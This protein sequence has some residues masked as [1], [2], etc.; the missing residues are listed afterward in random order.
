MVAKVLS[1][2][3][4]ILHLI[5]TIQ[6]VILKYKRVVINRELIAYILIT[7]IANIGM[8]YNFIYFSYNASEIVVFSLVIPS[9]LV[10][11]HFKQVNIYLT[12]FLIVV[13]IFLF[14]YFNVVF[15]GTIYVFGISLF[16]YLKEV[17]FEVKLNF[18][19]SILNMLIL[20]TFTYN[21]FFLGFS[22][23]TDLWINSPASHAILYIFLVL[24]IL[25]YSLIF[26]TNAKTK[27]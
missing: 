3:L 16:Y 21:L 22:N 8:K 9:M 15:E 4:D 1:N 14:S 12:C 23:H 10:V 6:A 5:I 24:L 17:V 7:Y 25:L 20:I 18:S 26:F 2:A 19:K 11:K 27:Y 13:L